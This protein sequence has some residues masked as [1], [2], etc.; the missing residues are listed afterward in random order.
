MVAL[1]KKN[2]VNLKN[3]ISKQ[4]FG[5]FLSPKHAEKI[6]QSKLHKE[7]CIKQ[8]ALKKMH[9]A[10]FTYIIAQNK[11]HEP[12]YTSQILPKKITTKFKS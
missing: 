10:N 9:S 7:N 11:L 3:A 8:L 1:A 2:M 4:F 5:L 12:N 6:T